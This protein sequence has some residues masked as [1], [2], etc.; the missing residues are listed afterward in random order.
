VTS[1]WF[2]HL[3]ESASEAATFVARSDPAMSRRFADTAA[4]ARRLASELA[5]E[6]RLVRVGNEQDVKR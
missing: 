4:A 1:A 2:N 6:E 3:A 5:Q